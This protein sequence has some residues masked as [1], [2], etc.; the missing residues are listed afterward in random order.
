[1]SDMSAYV[2]DKLLNWIRATAMG[3]APTTIYA[4]LYNGDPDSGGSE[5][6]GTVNLTRQAITW[7]A[8]SARAMSNSADI[9][10]GT[11]NGSATATY[12][13][14]WDAASTGNQISKKLITTAAISN[15]EIVAIAAAAL[16]LS[17]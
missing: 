13:V 9:T 10:F 3:T 5:V 14:L 8:V 2:G 6:T 7:S 1:M 16:A 11:A 12:V 4:S 15:G 17:Y